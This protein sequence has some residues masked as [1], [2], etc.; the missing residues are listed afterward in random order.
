MTATISEA[1]LSRDGSDG[2]I[3]PVEHRLTR[4]LHVG[5]TEAGADGLHNPIR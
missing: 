4:A 5:A 1:Y 2:D 3:G